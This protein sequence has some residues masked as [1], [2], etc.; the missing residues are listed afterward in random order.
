MYDEGYIDQLLLKRAFVSGLDYSF[1]EGSIEIKAPHFVH[2]I[3][4]IL[5]EEYEQEVLMK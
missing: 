1:E 5:E 4:E 3:Q 2:W